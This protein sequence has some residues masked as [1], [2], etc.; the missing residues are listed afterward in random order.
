[1]PTLTLTYT[2]DAERLT[3]ERALALVREVQ[4]AAKHAPVGGV[5]DRCEAALLDHGRPFL[6]ATLQ[7]VLRDHPAATDPK[8][9]AP[10]AAAEACATKAPSA[11][12]S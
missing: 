3:L 12:I 8:K 4:Q 10:A 11:G 1:M 6:A 5:I 9:R 2:T 7:N